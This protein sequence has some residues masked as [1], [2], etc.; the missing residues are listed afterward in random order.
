MN[1]TKYTK[2]ALFI[3]GL[4][5][6]AVIFSRCTAP[7]SGSGSAATSFAIS[8]NIA[9]GQ[10]A[11]SVA[12]MSVDANAEA[13][14]GDVN[15][16]A[17]QCSDGFYYSVQ[18]VSFSE[19]PVAATGQVSCGGT[20][21][22]SF[23]VAGLPL[24]AEI[25][26][27]VRR[28]SDNTTFSTLGTIQIPTASLTG[29]TTSIV[30]QGNL[31]LAI[32]LNTD[33][34]I[35]TTVT[36]GGGNVVTPVDS[37]AAV[38]V[39]QY[40]GFWKIQCD[41][42]GT[43]AVSETV[44]CKCQNGGSQNAL[45]APGAAKNPNPG[46]VDPEQ[47]CRNDNAS[48][49]SD[50]DTSQFI[51]INMYKATPASAITTEN[52]SIIPAGTHVPVISVWSASNATT[53][54]RGS[55]G[56]GAGTTVHNKSGPDVTLAWNVAQVTNPIAWATT[57][58]VLLGNG[59]TVNLA[60]ANASVAMPTGTTT[61]GV[62]KNWVAALYSNSTG[63][64]CSW[65]ATGVTDAGCLA[66]FSERV[67]HDNRSVNLPSV[68]IDRRCDQGGC[69]AA[70]SHA[71]VQVE[72]Y[73]GDY[74]AVLSGGVTDGV[75]ISSDGIS[76]Q[77]RNRYVFEP[78]EASPTG[79]GFTQ[80]EYRNRNFACATVAGSNIVASPA[81]TAAKNF[82]NCGIR[83]ETAIHFKPSSLTAMKLFF[84][85]RSNVTYATLEKWTMGGTKTNGTFA[86]AMAICSAQ[87][88]AEE[89]RF[90]MSAAKQ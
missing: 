26:C 54:A 85:Q 5:S 41:S 61:A 20:N 51:E 7:S 19:P 17:T 75:T 21:S 36:G 71:F 18:C 47:A 60:A 50:L 35:T 33:G 31:N 13:V 43:G 32:N 34:S 86:E 29:G 9:M 14:V 45:Y 23:T 40:N 11:M 62:W 53:S 88:S 70:V 65:G 2:P 72:G 16:L 67:L 27:F 77:V 3:G 73:H 55:G 6:M 84:E 48:V 87:V 56:E 76:P 8:G 52:G 30:S 22:G 58:S 42:T 44:K 10:T 59:V 24:N 28:S 74:S 68:R 78:F 63:F 80:H 83:E 57:G 89:G 37:G 15:A 79:G 90:Y 66:E 12:S 64:V 38:D 1:I 81:C 69:D 25:G 82:V 46:S 4:L 49:V 39:A